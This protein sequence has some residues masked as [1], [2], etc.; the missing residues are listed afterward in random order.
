MRAGVRAFTLGPCTE[1]PPAVT[2]GGGNVGEGCAFRVG[3]GSVVS[4]LMETVALFLF[5]HSSSDIG[6]GL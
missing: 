4:F 2:E 6:G 1:L 3:V 5:A